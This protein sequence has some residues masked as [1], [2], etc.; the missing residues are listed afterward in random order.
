MPLHKLSQKSFVSGQYD[1]TAQNQESVS[2][3]GI[4]ATGLSYAKNVVS[5]DK[6]E[7]RKRL[8]TKCLKQLDGAAVVV[9]F[10]NNENDDILLFSQNKLDI[11]SYNDGKVENFQQATDTKVEKTWT[12]DT[13]DG[14]TV[15]VSSRGTSGNAAHDM[16]VNPHYPP[17]NGTESATYPFVDGY[18]YLGD[19]AGGG[20]YPPNTF[21]MK[22][23]LPNAG[24]V[25]KFSVIFAT[26]HNEGAVPASSGYTGYTNAVIQYS[27][28]NLTW[29]PART[30]I[31]SAIG[32][33]PYLTWRFKSINGGIDTTKV[34]H[35]IIFDAILN[36][37]V[38]D[39][40]YWRIYFTNPVDSHDRLYS[41]KL[42]IQ[43]YTRS[44]TP[45]T[46]IDTDITNLKNIKYAQSGNDMKIA[47]G[48]HNPKTV[49]LSA[50]YSYADFIPTSPNT[51]WSDYGKPSCVE[52]FQNRL[53]WSG[54]TAYP[55][56]VIA[57]KFNTISDYTRNTPAQ[58]D[59]FLDPKCNQL[60]SQITNIKGGQ[61]V[62]YCFSEDGISNIDGGSTGLIATN[63]N[64]E[65]ILKNH[66]PAGTSTPAFK[67]DVMLYSSSDGTKL[68]G[69]DFDLLVNRFQVNDLAIYAKDVTQDKV[70]E[71][72]YVNNEAKLVYGLTESGKMFALLY[73]KGAYQGFFP[74]DFDGTVYDIAPIK[75]GRDYKLLM[76]VFR[77]GNW[78]L[79]EK[80]DCGKY[81]D[82]S[83]PRLTDEEKKWA[84]YDNLENNIALDCYQ[85]Y[86]KAILADSSVVDNNLNT[87]A[88]LY[89]CIGSSVMLANTT[90]KDFVIANIINQVSSST[91]TL[92]KWVAASRTVKHSIT[93]NLQRNSAHDT[94]EIYGFKWNSSFYGFNTLNPNNGSQMFQ[95]DVNQNIWVSSSS[96]SMFYTR[97][98][99]NDTGGKYYWAGSNVNSYALTTSEEPN[100]NDAFEIVSNGTTY[101]RTVQYVSTLTEPE[102]V[103][104]TDTETPSAGDN[105]YNTWDNV[106]ATVESVSGS[107]IIINGRTYVR[108]DT[109][110]M[111]RSGYNTY[112][113][114]IESQRGNSNQFDTIYPEFEW[115]ESNLPVNTNVGVIAEGRYFDNLDV[116]GNMIYLP[117]KCYKVIYGL[118]YE[119]VAILKIQTPYESLKQVAQVDVSVINTTHL[120][121][122]TDFSDTQNIEKIDDSS[123]YDLTR[124]TMNDTYRVVVSDT[125]EMTKNVILR[126]NKGVPF[127]VNAVDMYISYSN[128]GGD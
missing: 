43:F 74:L 79:E 29:T 71:L 38:G 94:A 99:E 50:G 97:Q 128:L 46:T 18:E 121:V 104:Y 39:H 32:N 89:G 105:V 45:Y 3:G 34:E 57:S 58:A 24:I 110:D 85:T 22:M 37:N 5:S 117:A 124:I 14:Y 31:T 95:W 62:L 25:G 59:D 30:V 9:P 27:D 106:G 52:Y 1:R 21:Y 63:Q 114:T 102:D 119:S 107:D 84:T 90:N 96:W 19:L 49:A 61:K 75:V 122:G 108:D 92:Y 12:S 77:D 17:A 103:K 13:V 72:H 120:E 64:I 98:P 100:I 4:V 86:D 69:V 113:I 44:L 53:W 87:M 2:G 83:T 70:T 20:I 80:L 88:N 16:F 51:L 91:Q 54:F 123:Y 55:T 10:R 15:S 111:T 41:Q 115:F 65:F 42:N 76:V 116:Q 127:T 33:T 36:D 48:E 81:I 8:G 101:N 78:Y 28:D 68:Y 93:A 11:L 109:G 40:L 47:D 112:E 67:D 125:P 26:T 82:T 60:K 7:V 6:G 73:E 126:S 35:L 66:M 56:L 23:E 118:K